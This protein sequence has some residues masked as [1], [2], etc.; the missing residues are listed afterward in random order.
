[1]HLTN[2]TNPLI[3]PYNQFYGIQTGLPGLNVQYYAAM[4]EA[5]ENRCKENECKTADKIKPTTETSKSDV[6]SVS[7]DAGRENIS[8]KYVKSKTPIDP[9]TEKNK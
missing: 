9:I 7:V 5:N 6:L 2:Y 4:M 3:W 1:M 8:D